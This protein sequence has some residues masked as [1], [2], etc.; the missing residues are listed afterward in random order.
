MAYLKHIQFDKLNGLFPSHPQPSIAAHA[1]RVEV[2]DFINPDGT[3]FS[4]ASRIQELSQQH[5]VT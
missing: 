2:V 5:V 4:T 1:L 3:P